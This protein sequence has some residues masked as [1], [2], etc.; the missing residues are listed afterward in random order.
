MEER[1]RSIDIFRYICAIMVVAI[2]TQPFSEIDEKLGY[3]F[4]EIVP[5]IA[6]PFFFAVA[7]YFYILGLR[8][9]KDILLPYLKRI[10]KCYA[11]WSIPYFVVDFFQWGHLNLKGFV[12]NCIYSF[13]TVGSHYHFWFFPA[14]IFSVCVTTAMYKTGIQKCLIPMG[15]ALYTVG[16][17]GCSYRSWGMCIPGLSVLY[18]S[19]HFTFIRRMLLMAFPFFTSG[20]LVYELEKVCKKYNISKSILLCCVAGTVV[21]WLGEIIAVIHYQLQENIVITFGLYL[22]TVMVL[23]FLLQHPMPQARLLSNLCHFL[24]DFTYYIHPLVISVLTYISNALGVKS[25]PETIMF[26]LVA[27][28]TWLVGIFVFDRKKIL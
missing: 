7:G 14:L 9:K 27:A 28:I 19:Q 11:I 23:V 13:T 8:R 17:F 24:A 26:C 18:S 4:T 6:V 2:H 22:L 20:A 12:V 25:I 21:C 3:V 5:R 1:N 10:L 15:I 16:C